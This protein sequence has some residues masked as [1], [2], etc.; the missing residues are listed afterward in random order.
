MADRY[1][2]D[3]PRHGRMYGERDAE[4]RWRSDEGQYGMYRGGGRYES[5]RGMHGS[6]HPL[7]SPYAGMG[8]RP[9]GPERGGW[10]SERGGRGEEHGSRVMRKVKR[11]FGM[12]PKGYTRGDERIREDVCERLTEDD[13]VDASNL[14]VRVQNGEVT[15]TGTVEDRWQKRRA[16]DV[17]DSVRGVKDVRNELRLLPRS[18]GIGEA[19][20]ASVSSSSTGN[21]NRNRPL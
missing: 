6:E 18:E 20:R 1:E 14:E 9:W 10:T 16:E 7:S 13:D 5:E 4:E 11:F 3:Y 8:E 2:R 15:L 19:T 21:G 12:G 17:A